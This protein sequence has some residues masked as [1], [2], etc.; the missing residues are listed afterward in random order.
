MVAPVYTTKITDLPVGIIALNHGNAGRYLRQAC[1]LIGQGGGAKN[2][3]RLTP[4]RENQRSPSH[5]L[6]VPFFLLPFFG[7]LPFVFP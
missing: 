4:A 3:T 5:F 6:L 1:L 7:G 2:P